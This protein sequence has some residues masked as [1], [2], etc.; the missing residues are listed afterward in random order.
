MRV[1]N[2]QKIKKKDPIGLKFASKT[3]LNP[4]PQVEPVEENSIRDT[5]TELIESPNL[6]K[7]GLIENIK[8][9]K[10]IVLGLVAVAGFFAYKKFKK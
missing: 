3:L 6:K 10:W 8:E 7:H 9:K 5:E 2:R 1:R 4:Q